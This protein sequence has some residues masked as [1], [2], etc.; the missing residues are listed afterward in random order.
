MRSLQLV[1]HGHWDFEDESVAVTWTLLNELDLLWW[2]GV[3]HLLQGVSSEI[4]HPD[5][6]FWSDVS[7]QW[8]RVN[9]LDDFISGRWSVE[10]HAFSINLR[11]LCA[12]RLGL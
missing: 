2:S 3:H 11:E 5:L 10:E 4:P 9:L 6:L 8:W 7:D 12:I 1:F